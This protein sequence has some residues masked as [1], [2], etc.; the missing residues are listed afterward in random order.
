MLLLSVKLLCSNYIN[1]YWRSGYCMIAWLPVALVVTNVF[2]LQIA[3]KLWFFGMLMDRLLT[4]FL[5]KKVL[6]GSNIPFRTFTAK[7]FDIY[8]NTTGIWFVYFVRKGAG[9]LYYCEM[10]Y[11]E[12]G[13]DNTFYSML[14]LTTTCSRRTLWFIGFTFGSF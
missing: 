14:F 8:F 5:C 2:L 1:S 12:S 6:S 9:M 7:L 3:V 11:L 13:L 4:Q 10:S